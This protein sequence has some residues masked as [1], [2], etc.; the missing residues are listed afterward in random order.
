[1]TKKVL[2]KILKPILL[3]PYRWLR[4]DRKWLRVLLSTLSPEYAS[5][6]LYKRAL[7]KK[8]NLKNPK[9]LNEKCMWLK[10]NT[11]YKNPL[12]T[13][14]CDKYL[15]RNYVKRAGCEEL[16]NELIGVWDNPDEINF[17]TLP[18]RFVLKGNH[19]CGYNIIVNDKSKLNIKET[20]KQLA[21]WLKEDYWKL[22]A[23]TQYK[24]IKKKII[25][26]K[27][28]ETQHNDLPEDYKIYCIN[29]KCD[30]LMFCAERSSGDPKFYFF[31]K[32]LNYMPEYYQNDKNVDKTVLPKNISNMINFAERLAAPFPFVRV[33]LY[34]EQNRIYF[35]ELTFLP[36]GGIESNLYSNSES[37]IN[38][39]IKL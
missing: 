7:G 12:I 28:I 18:R 25:C 33:D 32:N 37:Q 3:S 2:K 30:V 20:K 16:L 35:G 14:C 15:V 38:L 6:R 8:L 19:G 39:N 17:D 26:E 34:S 24:F 23:E 36:T 27:L 5:K 22:Y 13:E 11:Y 9:T 4:K 29:G 21:E 31:D 10:L 1:M